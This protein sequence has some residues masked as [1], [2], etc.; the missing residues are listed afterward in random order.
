MWY[1]L[2]GV[3]GFLIAYLF[4]LASVRERAYAK[5]I[6]GLTA[7]GVIGYAHVGVTTTGDFL[8]L[9]A[10]VAYVGWPVFILGSAAMIY[11][12]FLE[13]PFK[14]TYVAEGVGDTLVTT[15]TY[16]LVRHPG[17]LWYGLVLI[18]LIFISRREL[19]LWAAPVWFCMD[20]VYV[21][22]QERFF[23]GEM[24]SEYASYAS[25]TPMLIPTRC[26]I[27]RCVRTFRE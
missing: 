13:I 1:L 16:A 27:R 6:V 26:S 8:P 14:T 3:L 2:L 17:V 15:G 4:D 19:L 7:L 5:W 9:P 10:S 12:L 11:S 18:G 20:I 23:F 25:E 22:I 21:W 24:F